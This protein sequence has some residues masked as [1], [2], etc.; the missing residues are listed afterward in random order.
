MKHLNPSL[1]HIFIIV[2]P[3]PLSSG[4]CEVRVD[5]KWIKTCQTVIPD[6]KGEVYNVQTQE[7]EAAKAAFFS[8]KSLADGFFNNVAGMAVGADEHS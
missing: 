5:G 8:P 2:L 7:I 1:S 4:T 6:L 3:P